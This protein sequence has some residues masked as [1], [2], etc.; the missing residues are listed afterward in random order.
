MSESLSLKYER[1]L[2]MCEVGKR[3]GGYTQ[4]A[5]PCKDNHKHGD[6][7]K[8]ASLGLHSNGISFKCFA[9]CQTDTFLDTLGLTYKDLFPDDER[10][11]TNIYSYHNAD[12]SLHHDKVKYRDGNGK[13][14]FKQRTIDENGVVTWAASVGIPYAYPQLI[15]AIKSS[16]IICYTEGEKDAETGRILGFEAT[17]MGGASD[18]KDEYKIFFKDANLVLIPDKDDAGLRLTGKMVESLKP[19]CKSLKILVLPIGKDLTEWV[20]AGNSDLQSLI[21]SATELTTTNGVPEP[22]VKVIVG[23]YEL[24]WIG[25]NI[26]VV[27]DHI[28][29][30]DDV[31]IAVYENEKPLY[32]SGYKLLSVQHKANLARSLQYVSKKINWD[33]IVNQITVQ[34]L[35]RIREGDPIVYLGDREK[36][37][38]PQYLIDPLFPKNMPSIIYAERS[39]AKSL[40]LALIDIL[41]TLGWYDNPF[42]LNVSNK[43]YK[44]LFLDWENDHNTVGWQIYKML[45]GLDQLG[46]E[47][48]Y[49][50]CSLPLAKCLPQ[51][52]QKINEINADV[53]IIDSLAVAVGGNTNDSEPAL[54]FFS[55]LRQLPVTP[56]IIAHTAKDQNNRRK[57]V[58]GNAFYENLARSIWEVSKFQAEGSSELT[59]SLYQRKTPPFSGYHAP[60][61]FRF[62]FD[63]DKI[64]VNSCNPSPD[65]RDE[66]K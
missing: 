65:Q 35:S 20:E 38:K 34:C 58:Y 17:T 18:W 50:H 42:G 12:G 19:V 26:K 48:A 4:I 28:Q 62:I 39:S 66:E 43:G 2:N 47:L 24:Y 33:V 13:K 45:N 9:G 15:D 52:Q 23:G 41:L 29:N 60:L 36:V 55:A 63:G 3:H 44:V 64:Y 32:I 37:E 57:T 31:E 7:E 49:L 40:F 1:I 6:K 61:G 59:L 16:K 5:C 22:V 54:N 46:I 8:S 30:G 53:I 21:N 27:V 14:T 25:L 56:L 51:I 10:T 11:P